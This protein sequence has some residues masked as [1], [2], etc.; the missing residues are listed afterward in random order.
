MCQLYSPERR[1][2]T[3][4]PATIAG[5]T[6][7]ELMIMDAI[8]R[9][10]FRRNLVRAYKSSTFEEIVLKGTFDSHASE[11]WAVWTRRH[12]IFEI[13]DVI[14]RLS[15][16]L[17]EN[18]EDTFHIIIVISCST[19]KNNKYPSLIQFDVFFMFDVFFSIKSIDLCDS[20]LLERSHH[21][22][23]TRGFVK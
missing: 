23:K 1:D 12:V 3:L 11:A 20:R 21:E 4:I 19:Q 9:S 13:G 22:R 5:G 2:S 10:T 6:M 14:N 16:R 8:K 7:D 17:S 18:I 15:H